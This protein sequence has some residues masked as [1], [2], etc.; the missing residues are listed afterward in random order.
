MFYINRHKVSGFYTWKRAGMELKNPSHVN[1]H[2]WDFVGG[3]RTKY[4]IFLRE[5]DRS[6][7][8]RT[9]KSILYRP[10]M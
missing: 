8:R 10:L 6:G 9:E 7:G 2:L 1:V 3:S 5:W 4:Y